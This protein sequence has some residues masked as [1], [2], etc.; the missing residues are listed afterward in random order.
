[1]GLIGWLFYLR[2]NYYCDQLN[3][4]RKDKRKLN[5]SPG[6]YFYFKLRGQRYVAGRAQFSEMKLMKVDGA[7]DYFGD[8]NGV[9]S[10]TPFIDK[11]RGMFGSDDVTE[12]ST[13]NCIILNKAEWLDESDY[14]YISPELFPGNIL[15][16]KF[17]SDEQIRDIIKVFETPKSP[18]EP[19]IESRYLENSIRLKKHKARERNQQLISSVK[20]KR[21]WTCDVCGLLFEDKYGVSYI[22]AHHKRPLSTTDDII[23]S[24]ESDIALLCPNC[25]VAIH[26]LMEL[27]PRYDYQQIKE[28]CRYVTEG[29]VKK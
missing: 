22:E 1:M 26:K 29:N 3:F 11:I 5:L 12:D 24:K 14:P 16:A 8:R 15:G 9:R 25:H 7:W 6:D 2:N 18:E 27:Y 23:L 28:C 19:Y 4:W 17:F 21:P 13:I 20:V 10:Y